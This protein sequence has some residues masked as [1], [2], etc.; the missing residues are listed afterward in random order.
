VD[1]NHKQPDRDRKALFLLASSITADLGL[2][3]TSRALTPTVEK[4]LLASSI[5]ADLGLGG[6]TRALTPTIEK[7]LLAS[8]IT[9]DLGL[10]GTSRALTPTS[11]ITVIDNHEANEPVDLKDLASRSSQSSAAPIPRREQVRYVLKLLK[12]KGE[13]SAPQLRRHV[14]EGKGITVKGTFF[15]A[16]V[17][18]EALQQ[19][20]GSQK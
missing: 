8:S 4:T 20:I 5:T 19:W 7:T 2:G 1:Q 6:T 13:Q 12:A 10:G 11:E 14:A 18:R 15:D 17:L 9:A 16:N 3:G